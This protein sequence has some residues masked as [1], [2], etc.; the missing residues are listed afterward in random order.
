VC[1]GGDCT[2]VERRLI[3]WW[4]L[5]TPSLISLHK[6]TTTIPIVFADPVGQGFVA[7]ISHPGGNLT[8]FSKFD[9]DI[10]S[11]WLQ[12]LKDV[13]PSVM[14]IS[15]M[16]NPRTSPCNALWFRQSRGPRLAVFKC[17][18]RKI[19]YKAMRTSGRQS[20]GLGQNQEVASSFRPTHSRMNACGR[21]YG[22]AR[23]VASQVQDGECPLYPRKQTSR[24][25]DVRFVS[26]SGLRRGHLPQQRG[27]RVRPLWR[28]DLVRPSGSSAPR[29]D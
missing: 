15:V 18:C 4:H 19:L 3:F 25:W 5:E 14:H 8:G 6:T 21:E 17:P 28:S 11:K 29:A 26:S 2:N 12:V 16:F 10:G 7:S 13:A 1:D 23:D 20:Q 24:N 22:A 27:L 9:P